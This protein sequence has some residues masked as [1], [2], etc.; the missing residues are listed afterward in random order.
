MKHAA[1]VKKAMQSICYQI[2]WMHVSPQRG[3]IQ[4][5]RL[6]LI[7]IFRHPA[8]W[9]ANSRT[10]LGRMLFCCMV[11]KLVTMLTLKPPLRYHS[12]QMPNM[13]TMRCNTAQTT[14]VDCM[15]V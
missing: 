11:Y 6:L 7:S 3:D 14:R 8:H 4:E 10:G 2:E 1:V 15:K 12:T 9:I 5:V 13:P